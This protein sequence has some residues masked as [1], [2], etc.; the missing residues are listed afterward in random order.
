MENE[1][2]ALAF[3]T[4]GHPDRLAVFRLLLRFAPQAVRPTEIAKAL[5]LRQNTLSHHLADLTAAGLVTVQR[6]GRSLYYAGNAETAA[7]L[8]RYIAFDMGRAR[9]EFSPPPDKRENLAHGF[10]VLFICSR[11]SARSIMAEVLL[12]DLGKGKFNAF[13]AGTRPSRA[14]N[15]LTLET[16]RRHGHDIADLRPKRLGSFQRA[17]SPQMDFIFTVCDMAAT[18]ECAAWPGQ[19]TSAHWGLPDPVTGTGNA[20][21]RALTFLQTYHALRARISAFAALPISTLDR[22]RLQAEVDKLGLLP[23]LKG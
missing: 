20:A 6:R 1:N 16:L 5:D 21:E 4:L 13:S 8:M 14:I 15:A 12:R 11:N 23:V 3:S 18:E 19:P 9:P 17:D 2:A 10:N 22:N 7:R